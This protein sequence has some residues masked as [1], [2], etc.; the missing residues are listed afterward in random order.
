MATDWLCTC[1]L[2]PAWSPAS[3]SP[4]TPGEHSGKALGV[5]PKCVGSGTSGGATQ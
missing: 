2:V 5:I 4:E 1:L 3:L